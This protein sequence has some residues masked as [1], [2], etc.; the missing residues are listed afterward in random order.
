MINNNP[1]KGYEKLQKL[2]KKL[3]NNKVNL[4]K[5]NKNKKLRKVDNY[6]SLY[7]YVVFDSI[8]VKNEVLKKYS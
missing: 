7:A 4:H 1:D 8:D 5:L 3:E 6:D 2:N